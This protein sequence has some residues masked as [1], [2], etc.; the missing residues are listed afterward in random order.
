LSLAGRFDCRATV[1]FVAVD[2][3]HA[4]KLTIHIL[5]AMAEHEREQISTRTKAALVQA[6]A[7]GRQLGGDRGNLTAD[8]RTAGNTASA[9]ARR[10]AAANYA[11]DLMPVIERLR[12]AGITTAR[13][14]AK[15]LNAEAVPT[16]SGRGQWQAITIQRLL[17]R[18]QA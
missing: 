3:P 2:N 12:A 5:A 18:G 15:A 17:A 14:L 11:R 1:E 16:P 13:G 10:K 4:N 8:L 9:E 7:R 6:K